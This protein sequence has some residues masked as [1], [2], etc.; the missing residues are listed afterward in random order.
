M[1]LSTWM[2]CSSVSVILPLACA[3][4]A[5]YCARSPDRRAA[6]RSSVVRR[7]DLHQM[8][9]IELAD[10][11]Q[12]LFH[13]RDFLVLGCFLRREARDFLVQLRDPLAQL[14]L[15]SGFAR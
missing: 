3:R 6:S 14:R 11:D 15:L 1:S 9:V 5:M 8:L 13:Q 4:E 10:A 2:I 7:D 12:L